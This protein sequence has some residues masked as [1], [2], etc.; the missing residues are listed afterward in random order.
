[1]GLLGQ[2]QLLAFLPSISASRLGPGAHHIFLLLQHPVAMN[3]PGQG[4]TGRPS[5]SLLVLLGH[6]FGSPSCLAELCAMTLWGWRWTISKA[7]LLG[8]HQT[9]GW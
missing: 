2:L 8:E 9:H 1:M 6:C 3:F 4:C 5:T 7:C